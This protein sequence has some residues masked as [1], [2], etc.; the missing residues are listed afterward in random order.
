MNT[1]N[2]TYQEAA[3]HF[4]FNDYQREILYEM[5]KPEYCTYYVRLMGINVDGD[6]NINEILAQLPATKGGDVVRCEI[7]NIGVLENTVE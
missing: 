6:A 5:M 2:L 1:D 3:D 7:E 4:G